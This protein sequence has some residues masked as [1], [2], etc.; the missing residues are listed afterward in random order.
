MADRALYLLM[1]QWSPARSANAQPSV[2]FTALQL[3]ARLA[4]EDDLEKT[5]EAARQ[6]RQGYFFRRG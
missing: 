3:E 5:L 1:F 6:S 4:D 2:T